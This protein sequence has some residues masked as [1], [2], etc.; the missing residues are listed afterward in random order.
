M[1]QKGILILALILAVAAIILVQVYVKKVENKYVQNYDFVTV[2]V[3]KKS[4]PPGS[5]LENEMID[6]KKVPKEYMDA[7]ALAPKDREL[8]L[9]QTVSIGLKAG[10]QISWADLG[11]R[12]AEGLSGIIKEGE[13][14]ITIP[15]DEVTG[16][17]GLLSPNDHVD[18][19]GTFHTPSEMKKKI[20]VKTGV[21]YKEGSYK[22]K[23]NTVTLL[24]NVTILAAGTQLGAVYEEDTSMGA[25]V[26]KGPAGVLGVESAM[27][28]R[29]RRRS[30]KRYRTV[31]LLVTPLEAQILTYARSKGSLSLSL[32]NPEDLLTVEELPQ[33]TFKD[34]VKPEFIIKTQKKRNARIKIYR[35]KSKR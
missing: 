19:L 22:A 3:A 26:P 20:N 5:T 8:V 11:V 32:R 6:E 25:A 33:I 30:E 14:A 35:G 10:Q 9:G 13:R 12:E 1:K 29:I 17:A 28:S 34:I 31:T 21:F 23:T 27:G 15:V 18:I 24:Q 2:L 7:N 16:V 4:I